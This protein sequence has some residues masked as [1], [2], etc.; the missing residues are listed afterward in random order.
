ME[1]IWSPRARTRLKD[2]GDYIAKDAPERA[3]QFEDRLIESVER[4]SEFP[5]SGSAVPEN[6]TL[7]QVVLQGY[8]LIY[9]IRVESVEVVTV[10]SPGQS[11]DKTL[12]SDENLTPEW[13]NDD[14][15]DL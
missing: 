14:D 15:D 10:I 11:F 3:T 8:R 5:E 9:R 1:I 4:L 2:I 7:R 12:L 6:K 13:L